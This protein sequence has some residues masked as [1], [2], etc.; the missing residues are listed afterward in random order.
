MAQDESAVEQA[1]NYAAYRW[2]LIQRKTECYLTQDD[3]R[4]QDSA[5]ERLYFDLYNRAYASSSDPL[6]KRFFAEAT[7]RKDAVVKSPKEYDLAATCEAVLREIKAF[8]PLVTVP[9][10]Q[11]RQAAARWCASFRPHSCWC[12]VPNFTSPSAPCSSASTVTSQALTPNSAWKGSQPPLKRPHLNVYTN[13]CLG[14]TLNG[15]LMEPTLPLP[16]GC[17]SPADVHVFQFVNTA[18]AAPPAPSTTY[19]SGSCPGVVRNYGQWYL[20][21]CPGGQGNSAAGYLVPEQPVTDASGKLI[22]ILVDDQPSA[23]TDAGTPANKH[24]YDVLMCGTQ[25]IDTFTWT[26]KGVSSPQACQS[27]NGS[28]FTEGDYTD[29]R[30]VPA[31]DQGLQWAACSAIGNI[32]PGQF[33]QLQGLKAIT[34]ALR[35][36]HVPWN[37]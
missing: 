15:I 21:A 6:A 17:S 25:L 7:Q 19:R 16:Q 24:F 36:P 8:H 14:T 20:D 28:R 11:P 32:E 35:C 29:L 13:M 5:A 1:G 37:E 27:G 3:F 26:I 12:E 33:T 23:Y 22:N 30:E 2:L 4:E 18:P 10:I 34:T 9:S 31:G